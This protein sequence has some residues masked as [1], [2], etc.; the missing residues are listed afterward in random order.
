MYSK[1]A[2]RDN[3]FEFPET[4]TIYELPKHD[5]SSD[6]PTIPVL[7]WRMEVW[8]NAPKI[9]G[10]ALIFFMVLFGGSLLIANS[11]DDLRAIRGK[12]LENSSTA[13]LGLSAMCAGA[14]WLR[15]KKD[16]H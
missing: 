8:G 14:W 1:Q 15:S 4:A 13:L 16:V 2:D 10:G 3:V 9:C 7:D 6:I 11:S 5:R 12:A